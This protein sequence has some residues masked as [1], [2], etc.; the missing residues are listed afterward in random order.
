M[1]SF[2][3]ELKPVGLTEARLVE[4]I[5]I[6]KS[7]GDYKPLVR[8]IGEVFSSSEVLS[9]SFITQ[10]TITPESK[11]SII[12]VDIK[13]VER[14]YHVLFQLENQSIE[15]AL[16]NAVCSLG[17]GIQLDLRTNPSTH[18]V[19]FLNQF[20]IVLCNPNLQS[21]EYI[22]F[23]LPAVLK[24]VSYL[25]VKLQ[26]LLVNYWSKY[27]ADDLKQLLNILHQL[28]TVQLVAGPNATSGTPVNDDS[29]IAA[30][31]K[32]MKL[33]FYASV[34]GGK[35]ER[36]CK[37]PDHSDNTNGKNEAGPS[38]TDPEDE[39]SKDKLLEELKLDISKSRE[40]LLSNDDF[41]NETL[42]D[43]IEMDRDF[44]NYKY[45]E[46]RFAFLNYPF[47]LNTASKSLGLYFDNRVRMYSERRL[48]MIFSFM[49]GQLS[50]PYLRLRVRRDHLIEDA[51]V[52]VCML[53][54]LLT[55]LFT[56]VYC[57]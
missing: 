43:K 56:D 40:P 51:L 41:I 6:C 52:W 1:F 21:P 33:L 8:L 49:Q 12:P 23:A 9:R 2:S 53:K 50:S 32:C 30:A 38:G 5:N 29:S 16:V 48:T 13:S 24:A 11:E 42:N 31:T 45:G 47:V 46:P 14:S 36:S 57:V 4:T 54:P 25:P 35:F 39:S 10:D 15:N 44:T 28:I 20:V 34:L 18:G 3:T 26:K 22:D 27:S 37:I 7:T 55:S 17:S 19:E